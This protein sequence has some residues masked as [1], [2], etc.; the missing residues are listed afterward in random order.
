MAVVEEGDSHSFLSFADRVL[1]L[2]VID[3]T[4]VQHEESSSSPSPAAPPPS[5]SKAHKSDSLRVFSGRKRVRSSALELV[6]RS[7][8]VLPPP[9][10]SEVVSSSL[11]YGEFVS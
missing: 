7:L 9:L 8:S 10:S 11:L 6:V 4:E 5:K 2:L 1:I 3:P